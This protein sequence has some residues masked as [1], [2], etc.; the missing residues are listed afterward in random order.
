MTAIRQTAYGSNNNQ[1]T[2]IFNRPLDP[3]DICAD[4]IGLVLAN[5]SHIDFLQNP[6]TCL[7][8]PHIEIKN[9]LNNI[10]EANSAQI[11]QTYALWDEITLGISSDASGTVAKDYSKAAFILNQ[12]YLAKFQKNFPFFKI[13][14]VSVY[15]EK[16]SASLDEA[17]LFMH[18]VHYMYLSCQVGLKP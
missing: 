2:N 3:V 7:A 17:H 16:R 1:L 12:L 15:C 10:D 18:L 14:A 4:K 5:I 6:E 8:P 9:A 13:H 11:E